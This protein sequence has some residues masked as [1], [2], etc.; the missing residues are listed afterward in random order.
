MKIRYTEEQNISSAS[1]LG[2]LDHNTSKW[3]I[4]KVHLTCKKIDHGNPKHN[5]RRQ[6]H[7]DPKVLSRL[8]FC[9]QIR[10][11]WISVHNRIRID[12]QA[13][14]SLLLTK[15]PLLIGHGKNNIYHDCWSNDHAGP[16]YHDDCH[17]TGPCQSPPCPFL[18]PE[19]L[20]IV[21]R[22]KCLAQG[23]AGCLPHFS[24][25]QWLPRVR[26][27]T[28]LKKALISS[29]A[30]PSNQSPGYESW[31]SSSRHALRPVTSTPRVFPPF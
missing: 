3:P 10:C 4:C 9:E 27:D 17:Q 29:K 5:G 28:S 16:D 19:Q 30:T 18:F 2:F 26:I 12:L 15:R 13:L 7:N 24:Q 22:H 14:Q 20:I 8:L 11:P 6:E 31:I 21:L 23:I 25:L 1:L